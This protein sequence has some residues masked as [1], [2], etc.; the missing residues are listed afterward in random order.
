MPLKTAPNLRVFQD[1]FP[2]KTE[3]K[4]AICDITEGV[5]E[6]VKKSGV[7]DGIVQLFCPGSTGAMTTMEYEP[8]LIQDAQ[9]F[10]EQWASPDYPYQHNLSHGDGNG[11]SHI[12]ALLLGPSLSVPVQDGELVLGTWQQIVFIDCD[13]RPRNRKLFVTAMGV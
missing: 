10:L 6:I 1:H 4:G 5:R 2:L 11:H 8:G 12:Q 3:G 13:N 7:A 9:A